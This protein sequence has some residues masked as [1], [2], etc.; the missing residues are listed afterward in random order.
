MLHTIYVF[1][2]EDSQLIA[3]LSK[4]GPLDDNEILDAYRQDVAGIIECFSNG[5]VYE[6]SLQDIQ[7]DRDNDWEIID[8]TIKRERVQKVKE[9][10]SINVIQ[11]NEIDDEILE[12][13][14]D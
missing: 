2:G 12:L 13:L 11:S 8:A 1:F 6:I 14:E 10:D 5:V 7:Y 3:S 4:I 9:I